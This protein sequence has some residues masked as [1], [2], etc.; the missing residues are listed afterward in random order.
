MKNGIVAGAIA[1]IVGGILAI[2]L[3]Y[4][5]LPPEVQATVGLN[6]GTMKW[7]TSQGGLNVI[8]GAIF[9]WIFTKV[10]NLVPSKG[11]S[12]GLI[13][14]LLIWVLINI[15]PTSFYML[16]YDPPLTAMAFGWGV[17]G[18]FI[19]IV[20]GLVLGALYKK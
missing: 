16:V 3:T 20:Y 14:S 19:R 15:Y 12:K 6:A 4:F 9:G 17:V 11:I 10:Y 8:W 13:F 7:F 5:T 18:L 2:T 1:G